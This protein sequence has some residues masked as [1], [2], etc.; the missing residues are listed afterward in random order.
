MRALSGH[1]GPVVSVVFSQ[2]GKRIVS[3]SH[4]RLIKIWNAET[5]ATVTSFVGVRCGEGG[6]WAVLRSFPAGLALDSGLR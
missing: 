4:D 5:G 6:G 2:N 1:T 3:G